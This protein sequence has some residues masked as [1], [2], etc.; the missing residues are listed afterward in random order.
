MRRVFG[1]LAFLTVLIAATASTFAQRRG[2]PPP[3]PR[4]PGDR[5][6]FVFVGGYFYDPFFGPYPWW[7]RAMYPFPY[8]P[9]FQER[10]GARLQV[11][12]KETA[13][14][15]DGFYA[16]I[17]DDFD[18]FFQRLVLPPG[19]HELVFYLEHYRT[20]HRRVYFA[21]GATFKLQMA[22][23]PLAA[24]IA[25]EQP[26]LAPQ[27][28]PPPEGSYIGP[29]TP[30]DRLATPTPPVEP[31][32]Q[33]TLSMRVDPKDAFLTIDGRLWQTSD[34][35]RYVI[36]L[37]VGPHRIEATK[38]GYRT[39]TLEIVVHDGET[40]TLNITLVPAG[41]VGASPRTTRSR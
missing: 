3:P 33:G 9:I 35:G 14:Y 25:S 21:P 18:G 7:D 16:G 1:V 40:A 13:V 4:H 6:S 41:D 2:A 27:P 29:K 38:A 30:L 31:A 17:V 23:V 26:W 12:P 19:G 8:Y 37:P 24:G 36:D 5:H 28:P 34:G 10:A 39:Y 11:T 32:A 22:M 15:V 20:E